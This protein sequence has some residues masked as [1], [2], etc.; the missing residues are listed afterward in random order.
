VWIFGHNAVVDLERGLVDARA[1]YTHRAWAMARQ[2]YAAAEAPE[3]A[4]LEAW[5][6]AAMLTGHDDEADVVRE[7]AHHAFLESGDHDGAARVAFWLGLSLLLRGEASRGRGWFGR[8]RAVVPADT[9]EQSVWRGY[10]LVTDGM[11]ALHVQAHAESLD[12]L[13]EAKGIAEGRGDVDLELLARNGHGQALL[14]VGR[15]NEGMAELDQMLVLATSAGANPQAVGQVYCAAIL[16]CRGCLDIERSV[17]WTQALDRW[18]AAQPDLMPYRG[19]CLVHRSEVL[20]LRGDW[21]GASHEIDTMIDRLSTYQTDMAS[22]LALYQRGELYRL[23]GEF[24]RAEEA[25]QDAVRA[26]HDPQPGLALL[27]LSQG[28]AKT[29]LVSLRRALEENPRVFVRARLLPAAAS[30]A[31]AAGDLVYA[32]AVAEEL[33]AEAGRHD[34]AYLRAAAATT[35]GTVLL[36]TGDPAAALTSL[37]AGLHE[38]FAM[39]APYETARCRVL[40]ARACRLLG[41]TESADLEGRAA[42]QAFTDLG[43][44]HDLSLLSA[45]TAGPETRQD[46]LTPRELE[47]LRALA[48]GQSNRE[49]AEQFVLSERTVARHVANIFLKLGLSSRAAATA[50]AYDHRLL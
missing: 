32:R 26:G 33:T 9:F 45:E 41:D 35:T 37:R 42:A 4:D 7:R 47:M 43:A 13:A 50:Y 30:A 34:S 28:R 5:G 19:Q 6:L 49:I 12:L 10:A 18:C 48:T 21:Q 40:I 22:G 23:R 15:A 14:A 8:M 27:R 2:L 39:R 36:A 29:A 24:G 25:Y 11:Q 46:G 1:A 16:V 3:P 17:E 20:Q 38:W 31:V 44:R